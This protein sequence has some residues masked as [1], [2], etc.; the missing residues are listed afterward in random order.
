[1]SLTEFTVNQLIAAFRSPEPTPGGGSAA[2]LAGAVG[3]ALLSMVGGLSRPRASSPEDTERLAEAG[4]RCAELSQGLTAL[5]DRDT[6]A[7]NAVVAAYRLPKGSDDEARRRSVR[8]QEALAEATDSPLEVMRRCAAALDHASVIAALGNR[9]ASSD[10]QCG[11]ELLGAGL[12]GAM[13]NVEINLSSLKDADR[14]AGIR[15]E[16]S[17]LIRKATESA[18]TARRLL[19]E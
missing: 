5:I 8:I 12:R 10:V 7:Y 18:D 1:M 3:A 9:S 13:L 11:L 14:V 17:G 6:D 15:N 16:A 2:A 19:G 4:G